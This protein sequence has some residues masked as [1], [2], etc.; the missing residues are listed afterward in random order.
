MN[1]PKILNN[2][3]TLEQNKTSKDGVIKITNLKT[4]Y[5]A[6]ISKTA[7]FRHESKHVEQK[8]E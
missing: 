7:W 6:D 2:H 3:S 4:Y 1:I 8:T 5:R